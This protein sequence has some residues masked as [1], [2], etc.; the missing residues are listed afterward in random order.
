MRHARQAR[1]ILEKSGI[2]VGPELR[3]DISASWKRCLSS[4][5]SPTGGGQDAVLDFSRFQEEKQRF[6]RGLRFARPE[7]EFLGAQVTGYNYLIAF[8]A[9]DGTVLDA[10]TDTEAAS[11]KLAQTII[12][13]S[14]WMETLRGTNALGL[15]AALGKQAT[16]L[17][18]EHFFSENGDISCIAAPVFNGDGSIAG[19]LDVTAPV[20]NRELHTAALVK[21]A[22]LNVSNRLF[23]EDF[24]EELVVLCHPR[25]EYLSTQSAGMMA[26]DP[27]GRLVG[28]NAAARDI[29]GRALD[30][31]G[32]SFSGIFLDGFGAMVDR[33]R[34][35]QC[36]QLKD[37]HG[38]SVYVRLRPTR[39]WSG[40]AA[41]AGLSS[42]VRVPAMQEKSPTGDIQRG[43]VSVADDFLMQH[44]ETSARAAT[45]GL[46]VLI[47]GRSG[48]GLSTTAQAIHHRLHPEARLV[49]LDCAL[50]ESSQLD[51]SLRGQ[52]VNGD[53][54]RGPLLEAEGA[55]TL[56]LDGIED[57]GPRALPI[58][59]RLQ[60]QLPRPSRGRDTSWALLAIR[61]GAAP[62]TP[63]DVD[64]FWGH[65]FVVPPVSQR[66]D[67]AQ[68]VARV[69]SEVAPEADVGPAVVTRLR[70]IGD[71]LSFYVLRRLL[72]QLTRND[73]GRSIS[74]EALN[75]LLPWMA[76]M[77]KVCPSCAGHPSKEA[78]CR[79]IRSALRDCDGNISL[80]ARRLGVS[81]TTI[82][83]HLEVPDQA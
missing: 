15:A 70:E 57:L 62:E 28:A 73:P 56:V 65:A 63:P 80:A 72:F 4:G 60:A 38:A 50:L 19:I 3:E 51:F 79:Q 21:M 71:G 8:G 12:P 31:E 75:G 6:E 22:S 5:M 46:P 35:G 33:I 55:A 11:G 59:K 9:P 81:R 77:R 29:L 30:Q 52:T 83:K 10:L 36:V 53:P 2:V 47:R 49:E 67:L 14:L 68:I 24:R 64:D 54:V 48:C 43:A 39:R 41:G 66:R 7:M 37:R 32:Q 69:L 16:V 34:A 58:V 82:Y 76:P 23:I 45:S 44:I 25:E 27:D 20:S 13:G 78:R 40:Q 61:R 18:P 74:V 26:F 17:G 1:R 42:A